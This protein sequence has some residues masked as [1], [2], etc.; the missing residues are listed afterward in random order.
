MAIENQLKQ[1]GQERYVDLAPPQVTAPKTSPLLDEAATAML[2]LSL[3]AL[4]QRAIV[5]LGNL[6]TL[7][8]CLSAFWLW[9]DVL[10]NPTS[11]QL[12]GLGLYGAFVLLLHLV[13]RKNVPQ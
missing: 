5:S 2:L 11:L 1:V 13:R 9:Q 8:T 7:L 12:V 3:K 10:P 6:F 4:S